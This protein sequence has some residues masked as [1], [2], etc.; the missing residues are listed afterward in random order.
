MSQP[1]SLGPVAAIA[2]QRVC[3]RITAARGA[4]AVTRRANGRHFFSVG[5]WNGKPVNIERAWFCMFSCI[6]TNR[7]FD[8]S[9]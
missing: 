9:M 1:A 3:G 4:T 2:A 5:C 8:C 6:C 7:F